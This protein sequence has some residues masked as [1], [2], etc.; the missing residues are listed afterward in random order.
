MAVYG[1]DVPTS[2]FFSDVIVY[3]IIR[4]WSVC[5]NNNNNNVVANGGG[6]GGGI[7]IGDGLP[8]MAPARTRSSVPSRSV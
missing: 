4:E 8:L 7:G 1:D 6:G 2:G 3:S 5:N